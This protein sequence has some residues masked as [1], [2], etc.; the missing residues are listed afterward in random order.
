M[1]KFFDGKLT[2][3]I[4]TN[5]GCPF[6][7]T[8]C[9]DGADTVN[10]V[11]QFGLDRV[12]AELDY[13]GEHVTNNVHSLHISDLNFGMYPRDLEICDDIVGIQKKHNYPTSVLSTTGKNK[14]ERIIQAIEKLNG[15]MSLMT[16]S[17][18]HLTLPT[19]LLV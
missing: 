14:K 13:I 6:T 2:P 7:C 9:V 19:I 1:D 12:S 3:M 15:T 10:R 5:R 16:V 8:F 4:Q 11:N 18:T 17:Y